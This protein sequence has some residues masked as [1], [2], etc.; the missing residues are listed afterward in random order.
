MTLRKIVVFDLDGTLADTAPDLVS[1]LNRILLREGLTP[2]AV[3]AARAMVG[4]GGRALLERGFAHNGAA[5]EPSRLDA[6]V[7]DFLVDYEARIAD[8]TRAFPGAED[9]LDALAQAGFAL[10]VCTNK[11]ERLA[12][13]LLAELK[14]DW[15]FAAICG[16]E[17]FPVCKPH[18]D[19]LLKTVAAAGGDPRRAIMV[20]DSRTDVDAAKNAG[21]PVIAVDFGYTDAPVGTFGPTMVISHFDELWDAAAAVMRML[22]ANAASA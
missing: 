12:R 20:G 9:A 15:R 16:R 7:E 11:P 4:H 6:L 10:A 21:A 14:L 22:D 5:L 13:L 3:D 19:A 18:G 1:A 2:V 8:E 17:T